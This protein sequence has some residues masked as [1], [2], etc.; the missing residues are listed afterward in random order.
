MF[1]WFHCFSKYILY[2]YS[3]ATCLRQ[4]EGYKLLLLLIM[5]C[6]TMS[7][8]SQPTSTKTESPRAGHRRN[9]LNRSFSGQNLRQHA[10][11]QRAYS[12]NNL[13]Y[14]AN[15]VQAVMNQPKLKNSRSM[16]GFNLNLSNSTVVNSPKMNVGDVIEK[17]EKK[18]G[19]WVEMLMEIRSRWVQKQNNEL[20]GDIDEEHGCDE[21][22]NEDGCEVDYRDDEESVVINQE[23]FSGMLKHVSWSDT[24][25]LSQLAFLCNMAYVIPE[26][27][28]CSDLMPV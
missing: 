13:C 11:I 5:A 6:G 17:E 14:A 12:D 1:E 2:S 22:G 20:D 28:V 21:D 15:H 19:N 10:R 25:H 4:S 24:K 27:E 8:S 9:I 26:I 16:G 23:T 7:V 3:S 18:R